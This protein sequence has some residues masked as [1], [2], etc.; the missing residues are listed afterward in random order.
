MC[1]KLDLTREHQQ[2]G[3]QWTPQ[4]IW[5]DKAFKGNKYN[6]NPSKVMCELGLWELRKRKEKAGEVESSQASWVKGL[7]GAGT[8]VHQGCRP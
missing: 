1:S 8:E 6:N 5:G 3:Y 4:A 2:A 7:P